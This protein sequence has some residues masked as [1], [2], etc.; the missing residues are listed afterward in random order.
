MATKGVNPNEGKTQLSAQSARVPGSS[1]G[2]ITY[3][4]T[5][6]GSDSDVLDMFDESLV[7][8]K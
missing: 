8:D 2:K 4:D 3:D 6:V 7:G 5:I 1:A